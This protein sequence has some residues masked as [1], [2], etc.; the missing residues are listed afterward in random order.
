MIRVALDL[1]GGD[2]APEAVLEAA[3]A[4]LEAWP[5]DLSLLLVGPGDLLREARTRFP[6]NQVGWLGAEE[7]I[8]PM[9]PPALAVR[10]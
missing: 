10:R 4:A 8:G 2:A 1:L 9:E 7:F 6:P 3:A 5:N